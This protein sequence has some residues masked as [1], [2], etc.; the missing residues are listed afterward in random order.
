MREAFRIAVASQA[1]LRTSPILYRTSSHPLQGLCEYKDLKY[2]TDLPGAKVS[3]SDI[4]DITAKNKKKIR[5][6]ES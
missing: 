6:N 4:I 1:L 2:K 5:V 3:S